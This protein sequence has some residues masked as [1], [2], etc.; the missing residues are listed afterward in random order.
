[1]KYFINS[2]Y[3]EVGKKQCT[4]VWFVDLETGIFYVTVPNIL[5]LFQVIQLSVL[6]ERNIEYALVNSGVEKPF[7]S[8]Y[9]L[10]GAFSFALCPKCDFV[11]YAI[12]TL[13]AFRNNCTKFTD[14]LPGNMPES[15][16][17]HIG[18]ISGWR[19]I[20]LMGQRRE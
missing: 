3:P 16:K 8:E 15:A 10:I 2:Q 11:R 20:S 7:I 12:T 6:Q 5:E 18:H 19:N 4:I 17:K 9:D 1:M 13:K 14:E